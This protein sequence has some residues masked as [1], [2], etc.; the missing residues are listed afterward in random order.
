MSGVPTQTRRP[1]YGYPVVV[2]LPERTRVVW[3]GPDDHDDDVLAADDDRVLTWPDLDACLAAVRALAWDEA[4]PD[5]APDVLDLRAA[6]AWLD[7]TRLD[8]DPESALAA[9][10]LAIDVAHSTDAAWD[11]SRD[12]DDG[13]HE[14]LTFA[15]VPWSIGVAEYVPVWSDDELR[16]L[17]SRLSAALRLVGDALAR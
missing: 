17:R 11:H 4:A 8:V 5:D 13:C 6:A 14:K 2:V 7:G 3:W 1:A 10:N 12:L 9:W 15:T 16:L